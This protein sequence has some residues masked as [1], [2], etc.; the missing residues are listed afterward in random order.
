[1]LGLQ[2][3]HLTFL[4]NAQQL[5]LHMGWDFPDLVEKEGATVGLQKAA[6]VTLDGPGERPAFVAEELG[7]ENRF[8]QGRAVDRNKGTRCTR[9]SGVDGPR[10]QFLAGS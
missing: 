4:Q 2:A 7:F 10:Q 8:R 6:I 1:M 5:H 3:L 9:R